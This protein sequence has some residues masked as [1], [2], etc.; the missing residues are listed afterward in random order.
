MFDAEVTRKMIAGPDA[1]AMKKAQARWDSIAKPLGSLGLLESAVVKIAG[2][3]GSA[4]VRID[5]RGVIVMCADNGVVC[6]GVTQTGQEITALVAGNIARGDASVC[7]MAS[8]AGADVFPIDIG[9]A[10]R[11]EDVI[12]LHIADG[13]ANIAAGPAMSR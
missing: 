2:L 1:E 13:T 10:N 11:A 12:D 5:R 8:I 6:E 4:D 9:M 3:T 7:R